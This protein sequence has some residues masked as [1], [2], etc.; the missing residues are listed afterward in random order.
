M[1]HGPRRFAK[2][3]TD[4][5]HFR[6]IARSG[7][8]AEGDNPDAT[9]LVLESYVPTKLWHKYDEGGR[10]E[11]LAIPESLQGLGPEVFGIEA[12]GDAP[13][14]DHDD[15]EAGSD[16]EYEEDELAALDEDCYFPQDGYNYNQHLRIVKEGKHKVG[17]TVL[18]APAKLSCFDGPTPA[19]MI[20]FNETGSKIISDIP[21]VET[22]VA[23]ELMAALEAADLYEELS[24]GD[25][26]DLVPTGVLQ[27]EVLLW[28]Q[29]A[30]DNADLPDLALFK[31]MHQQRMAAMAAS[32]EQGEDDDE[33]EGDEGAHEGGVVSEERF[34]Q[35]LE[36]EYDEEED[37]A[38]DDD[39][40][41]GPVNEVDLEDIL[42][43]YLDD[44]AAEK[45]FMDSVCEPQQGKYDHIPRT[46]QETKAI[47]ERNYERLVGCDE[48]DA[49]TS[50]GD[51]EDQTNS[52]S[53]NWD[54]ETVLSTLSNVSNRPGKIN[55]IKLV[56]KKETSKAL[57][58]IE[59]SGSDAESEE[60][61][62]AVELPDVC[63]ERPKNE[64]LEDK[65][66][67]KKGVK[68]MRAIC[69]RMKK[70]SKT[71]Y[72]EEEKKLHKQNGDGE[73]R[74][75]MRIMKL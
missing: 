48:A 67:R 36:D 10:D 14:K 69:R 59:E 13:K 3:S 39:E 8:D 50:D 68:E 63:F 64:S 26:E 18:A 9:P 57:E 47:I 54:C 16:E 1:P 22:D 61:K 27:P 2:N 46:V 19:E 52:E 25:L 15:D 29:S 45:Q 40:I 71:M 51:T 41:E 43:E 38:L 31:E 17:G 21:E 58:K 62:D 20:K 42:D 5:R 56:K 72:K 23:A 65:K 35:L 24:D 44:R 37:G 75:R 28:G 30:I 6:L 7:K 34:E 33:D 70:E 4:V 32:G 12:R 53:K 11:L 73:N 55:K 49:E 60:E 74:D 66:A